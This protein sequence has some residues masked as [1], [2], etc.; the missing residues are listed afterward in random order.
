[1][2]VGTPFHPAHRA[3]NRKQQWREWSGYFAAQR[4]RRRPRHR[5][6]RD[7]RGGRADRRQ[8]ALQVR[9]RGPRRARARR[10][11]HHP[12]RDEAAGRPGLLHALVR[13]ARQGHRRRHRPSARRGPSSA[14]P[15]PT[16][17]ALAAPERA[18]PRGRRSRTSPSRPP[19]SPSRARCA[20]PC[21]RPRPASRSATCA[22]SAGGATCKVGRRTVEVDV[23]R[24]GYTGDLG[25]ELWIPAERAAE[26]WDALMDAG[27]RTASGRRACSPSTSS[28]SRPA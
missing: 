4:L 11:R 12:R 5:V 24:T 18:R 9:V 22:T 20:A 16:R 3:L 14:G 21:S 7:P 19:R 6:Q 25:Y 15:P 26:V 28:G 1:M 10:P 13:R 27:A 17:S 8:P 23:S 2:S